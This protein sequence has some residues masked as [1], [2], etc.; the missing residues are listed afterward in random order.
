[1][2]DNKPT[3]K[4]KIR[5]ITIRPSEPKSGDGSELSYWIPDEFDGPR[6]GFVTFNSLWPTPN[7]SGPFKDP[8]RCLEPMHEAAKRSHIDFYLYCKEVEAHHLKQLGPVPDIEVMY[9]GWMK[10]KTDKK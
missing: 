7:P 5:E 8:E 9:D 6:N 4:L 1:M 2:H 10:S 3:D